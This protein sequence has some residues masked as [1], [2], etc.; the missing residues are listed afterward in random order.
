MIMEM[1]ATLY[2]HTKM[3]CRNNVK[4]ID[5]LHLVEDIIGEKKIID[6][7]II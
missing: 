6:L 5:E 4:T 2:L 3:N 7:F 1:W